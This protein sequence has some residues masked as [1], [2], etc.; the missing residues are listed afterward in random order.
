[1]CMEDVQIGRA[2][3]GEARQVTLGTSTPV[4]IFARN[5]YRY[6]LWIPWTQNAIVYVSPYK[7]LFDTTSGTGA[8][9]FGGLI[10]TLK[11]HG[12]LVR[13]PWFAIADTADTVLTVAE[14]LF[15]AE[16][17]PEE[18]TWN[19]MNMPALPPARGSLAPTSIR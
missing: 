10:L 17:W 9:Y 4:Q 19:P 8:L 16:K 6:S 13:A 5:Q 1:M 12:D 11:E 15:Y 7:A 14:S 2:S 3:A 18:P